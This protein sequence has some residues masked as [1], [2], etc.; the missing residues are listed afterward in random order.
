LPALTA[1]E[2]A[3]RANGE[4]TAGDSA[5]LATS[6]AFDT[7]VL[8]EGACF[9]AL[10]GERDGHDF[11]HEA[12]K[13]GASVALVSHDLPGLDRDSTGSGTALVRVGDTLE[14]LQATARSVRVE[15]AGLHVVGVAGSTGKT[16]TKDLLAA[17]LASR[18]VHA[19]L[20]SYNNEFGVPVTLLNT[21][22]SAQVAVVEMGERFPGDVA[23]LCEI[24]RPDVGVVTNVGLAHAE[25]LGGA[26]GAAAAM[27]ELVDALPVGGLAVLSADDP[28]TPDL[29]ARTA[30][31]VVTVGHDARADY[32]VDDVELDDQLRPSFRIAGRH[33][34]VPLHGGHQVVNA[35]MAVAVAHRVFGVD[36]DEIASLLAGARRGRWRMELTESVDGVVVLNDTYNA[37]PA[38]MEAAMLALA[39]LPVRGRRIAVLGDM[40]EL[41]DHAA[42]AHAH[43]GRRAAELGLDVVVGVGRGGAIIAAAAAGGL[44]VRTVDTAAEAIAV[45]APIVEP[46]DAV[47]VKASRALGLE[48][49]AHALLKRGDHA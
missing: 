13:A 48:T 16:S 35:A 49:V 20:E 21:P 45:V 2:I 39:H 31:D 47:L 18:G 25:H 28:F 1:A 11:V 43:A 33:M 6:W 27:A 30:A 24:A 7:R 37:N 38:S 26:E 15:R 46:G 17:A 8:E 42:G 10:Q 22:D 5:A 32:R 14:G 3:R 9:V 36:L 29:A 44:A 4:V 19:N 23:L 40:R 41:G 12:F 34:T